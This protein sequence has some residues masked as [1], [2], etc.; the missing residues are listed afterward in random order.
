M[1]DGMCERKG[2]FFL[3]A[4]NEVTTLT[5]YLQ[6]IPK[7]NQLAEFYMSKKLFLYYAL[8]SI[9]LK[10]AHKIRFLYA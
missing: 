2:H 6:M 10:C 4:K 9:I 1:I 7:N 8:Y 3:K 5:V